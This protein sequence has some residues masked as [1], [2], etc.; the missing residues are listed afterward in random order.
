MSSH[1]EQISSLVSNGLKGLEKLLEALDS[2]GPSLEAKI[3]HAHLAR[4]KLWAGSLGA[5]RSS[6]TRSLE[7]RLRDASSIRHHLVSLLTELKDLLVKEGQCPKVAV[8]ITEDNYRNANELVS[9]LPLVH[10]NEAPRVKNDNEEDDMD[11][12]L[13]AYFGEDDED[14]PAGSVESQDNELGQILSQIGG[15]IDCLLRLSVT[16]SNPAPHDRFKSR[17]GVEAISYEPWDVEHVR[18]KFP[19]LDGKVSERLGKTLTQRRRYFKYREDHH[20]RLK[21]GLDDIDDGASKGKATT[22]A[23]SLPQQFK[24]EDAQVNL[25]VLDDDR[26]EISATSYAPSTIDDTELRVPPIPKEYVDGPF[27]CPFCYVF[28]SVD[29]RHEWK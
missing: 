19:R 22:V 29:T 8:V 20:C 26:S 11:D 7:Y 12:E 28:I 1:R 9:A 2:E 27:L 3:A 24:D 4:F 14:E 17:A 5:H 10:S 25:I 21:Q 15:V 23:S 18:A 16:I 6:G 13:A